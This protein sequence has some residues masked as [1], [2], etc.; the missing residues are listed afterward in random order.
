[1]GEGNARAAR[2]GA[3]ST[4]AGL[5]MVANMLDLAILLIVAMVLLNR[6]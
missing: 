6:R 4:E 3:S 2:E 1:V 5:S